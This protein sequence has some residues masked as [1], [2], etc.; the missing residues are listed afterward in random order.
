M[1]IHKKEDRE[2]AAGCRPV[3]VMS[4]EREVDESAIAI[5][6]KN[7]YKF[8][9]TQLGLQEVTS[10]EIAIVRHIT[11]TRK[12]RIEVVLYLKSGT[13]KVSRNLMM[14]LVTRK[15]PQ[16]FRD[17]IAATLQSLKRLTIVYGKIR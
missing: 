10:T 14:G 3:A 7:H 5:E 4:H 8:L 6:V 1:P 15:L 16:H 13:Y 2:D 12:M 11:A 17:L 9:E